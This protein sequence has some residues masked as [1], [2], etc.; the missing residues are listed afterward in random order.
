MINYD[1]V[2]YIKRKYLDDENIF[3]EGDVVGFF[4]SLI[5]DIVIDLLMSENVYEVRLVG[6][7]SWLVYLKGKV[8][9][10]DRENDGREKVK[11]C[12]VLM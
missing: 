6:V 8:G 7:I 3:E 12:I 10:F 4:E 9:W 11:V 5:G 1:I 2:Y